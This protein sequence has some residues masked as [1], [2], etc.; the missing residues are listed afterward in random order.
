MKNLNFEKLPI[1]P[2]AINFLQHPACKCI[3]L[4]TAQR[5]PKPSKKGNRK[6][7]DNLFH[8]EI[9]LICMTFASK[10]QHGLLCKKIVGKLVVVESIPQKQLNQILPPTYSPS[11]LNLVLNFVTTWPHLNLLEIWP[12]CEN[13]CIFLR[14]GHQMAQ[15]TI[16][17]IN[18][19]SK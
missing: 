17:V 1:F 5:N 7:D 18:L 9:D 6:E 10:Q 2:V 11:Q 12:L 16:N 13:I 14:F 3:I 19:N 4:L 15:I 8:P